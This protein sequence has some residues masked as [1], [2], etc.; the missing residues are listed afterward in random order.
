MTEA[1]AGLDSTESSPIRKPFVAP[2]VEELGSLNVLTLQQ[3][4]PIFPGI[5]GSKAESGT[6]LPPQS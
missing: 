5:R 6:G 4:V 3:S 2:A 1:P